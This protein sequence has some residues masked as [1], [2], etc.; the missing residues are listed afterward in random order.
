MSKTWREI[1]WMDPSGLRFETINMFTLRCTQKLLD[2]IRP[3][4]ELPAP[5]TTKLGDWYCNLLDVRPGPLVLCMSE[6]TFLCTLIPLDYFKR[7]PDV[8]ADCVALLLQRHGI[9]SAAVEAERVEMGRFQYGKT[10]SRRVLGCLNDALYI[11]SAE[12]QTADRIVT[13][14]DV[15]AKNIYTANKYKDPVTAARVVLGLV[16]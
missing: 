5:P 8:M 11:A 1:Y 3:V 2:R 7:R 13:I 12:F 9:P 15:L 4:P 10:A 6:H 14:E 16:Q